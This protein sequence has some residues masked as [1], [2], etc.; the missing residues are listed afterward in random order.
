MRISGSPP[1]RSS[2][3]SERSS[4]PSLRVSTS[5]P[6]TSNPH[7]AALTNSDG[8]APTCA[9]Q[10]PRLDLVADQAVARRGVRDAQQRLG[11]AHQRDALAAVER[12]LE[13]QRVD[14]AGV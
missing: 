11:E 8:E 4:A 3:A 1:L 10:S 7:A 9:R 12:E 5:L 2:E 13:H 14:A 6:V